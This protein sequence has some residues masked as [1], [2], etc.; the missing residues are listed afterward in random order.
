[1]APH[2][3]PGGSGRPGN[4]VALLDC[5]VVAGVARHEHAPLVPLDDHAR[6]DGWHLAPLQSLERGGGRGGAVEELQV[7]HRR[8]TQRQL[9]PSARIERLARGEPS[10]LGDLMLVGDGVLSWRHRGCE[11]ASVEAEGL[12]LR[13]D[14]VGEVHEPVRREPEPLRPE[15]LPERAVILLARMAIDRVALV[16]DARESAVLRVGEQDAR[17]LERLAD[18]ADPVSQRRVGCGPETERA[19]GPGRVDAPAHPA[20]S[21]G[22]SLT[23]ILPPG[24]TKSPAANWLAP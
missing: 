20:A 13:R 21:A 19:R 8:I 18:D 16:V 17:L 1:M 2:T 23:S 15:H 24:N 12:R 9:A 5:S 6:K 11:E 14:P 7:L 10:D 22:P 4:P 3:P